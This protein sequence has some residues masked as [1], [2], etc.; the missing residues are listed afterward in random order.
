M[1]SSY[2]SSKQTITNPA[3]TD[4]LNNPTHAGIHGTVNDTLGSLQDTVGTTAGT[5]VLLNFSAGHFPLRVT[6][7]GA[8]GTHITTLV[9]GTLANTALIGTPQI[10]G[11]TLASP[12]LIGT[13]TIT[14]GTITSITGTI[15]NAVLGTPAITGGTV[16]SSTLGTPTVNTMRVKLRTGTNIAITTGVTTALPWDTED[17]DTDALHG[18]TNTSRITIPTG[19]GGIYLL[20]A[21]VNWSLNTNSY[22]LMGIRKNG[23]TDVA[24]DTKGTV[25]TNAVQNVACF[26]LASAADYYEVVVLHEIGSDGTIQA[27]DSRTF[28]QAIKLT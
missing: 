26:D 10:T 20:A 16:N 27:D 14:G 17:Y 2:P 18:T 11:G 8:T 3:T 21:N 15:N 28:F 12:A 25:P 13:P 23:G 22:R 4:P 6:G 7:G 24:Q 1:P 5:N 9:G 19:G